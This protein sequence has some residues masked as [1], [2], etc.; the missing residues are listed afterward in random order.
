MYSNSLSKRKEDERKKKR[1]SIQRV[2]M[3]KILKCF[4][5]QINQENNIKATERKYFINRS[6]QIIL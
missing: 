2:E 3:R 5:L 1:V 4:R 6:K